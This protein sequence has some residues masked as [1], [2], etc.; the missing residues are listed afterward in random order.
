MN[1][2]VKDVERVS[3][4]LAAARDV[5][6]RCLELELRVIVDLRSRLV[7]ATDTPCKHECLRLT[8][9]VCEPAL[10]ERNVEPILQAEP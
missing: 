5:G 2:D 1:V 9:G 7:V 6:R 8:P 4:L 10:D 3:E